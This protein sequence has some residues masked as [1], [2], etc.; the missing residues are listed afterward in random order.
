[1]R[2]WWWTCLLSIQQDTC[3]ISSGWSS[4]LR[5]YETLT[6]SFNRRSKLRRTCT[7]NCE[8]RTR[9]S[10]NRKKVPTLS[11]SGPTQGEQKDCRNLWLA[12]SQIAQVASPPQSL[13]I[14]TCGANTAL[15]REK[16]VFNDLSLLIVLLCLSILKEPEIRKKGFS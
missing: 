16:D 15:L 13:S 9:P 14:I 4:I 8:R 12:A 11:K 10:L 2:T 5:S 1:M 3:S 6:L 7:R